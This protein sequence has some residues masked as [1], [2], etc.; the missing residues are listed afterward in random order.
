MY[1]MKFSEFDAMIKQA[2]KNGVSD[3]LES[4]QCNFVFAS[5]S[6][7]IITIRST[8]EIDDESQKGL[9]IQFSKSL[10]DKYLRDNGVNF[11]WEVY[12]LVK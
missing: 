10:Y 11:L 4:W 8:C 6:G 12:E 3:S 1:G 9:S 2:I 7:E 5:V